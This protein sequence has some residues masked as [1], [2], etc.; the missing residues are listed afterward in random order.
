MT[1]YIA[2]E[3]KTTKDGDQRLDRL[4]IWANANMRVGDFV[5]PV[6]KTYVVRARIHTGINQNCYILMEQVTHWTS[7]F[8]N[9]RHGQTLELKDVMRAIEDTDPVK[10]AFGEVK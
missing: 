1:N 4:A 6:D 7:P 9:L 10:Q 8:A 3:A 2:V 5:R